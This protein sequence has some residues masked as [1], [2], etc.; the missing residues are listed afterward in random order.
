M[1]IPKE[2]KGAAAKKGAKAKKN[3]EEEKEGNIL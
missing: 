2:L 1:T 3:V